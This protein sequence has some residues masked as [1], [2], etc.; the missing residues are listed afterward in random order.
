VTVAHTVPHP[1]GQLPGQKYVSFALQAGG[2]HIGANVSDGRVTKVG[3]SVIGAGG[4]GTNRVHAISA[5]STGIAD[6]RFIL[7]TFL[8]IGTL[9]A[10]C[11][12]E[13]QSSFHLK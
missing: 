8:Q 10:R 3:D 13:K 4:A 6:N 11:N 7:K 12:R 1:L 9:V 5:R 2:V